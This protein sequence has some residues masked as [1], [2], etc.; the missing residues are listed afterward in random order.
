MLGRHLCASGGG[1]EPAEFGGLH[2]KRFVICLALSL[3]ARAV[4]SCNEAENAFVYAMMELAAISIAGIVWAFWNMVS[5]EK[6]GQDL[7]KYEG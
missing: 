5:P 3:A 4:V 6:E 1:Q 7:F 2:L